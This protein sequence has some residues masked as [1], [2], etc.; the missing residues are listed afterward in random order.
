MKKSQ[1]VWGIRILVAAVF[2]LSA[3]AKLYPTPATGIINFE[4]FYLQEGLG[5]DLSFSKIVSRLLIGLEFTL[6][7]LILLPFYLKKIVIPSIITLLSLFSFHLAIQAIGGDASNCGCFGELIPMTPLEALIKNIL[8]IGLLILPVTIFKDELKEKLNLNPIIIIGLSI[9]LLMFVFVPSISSF[10]EGE[11]IDDSNGVST[12][13]SK[14]FQDVDKGNKLLCFFSPTCEH[15]M[16]TGKEITKLKKKYPGLIP[17]IDHIKI[18]FMD[19]AGNG[20]Q[21]EIESFFDY[22]GANYDYKVLPDDVFVPLF[23]AEK[24]F[25]G[26]LYMYNGIERVFFDGIDENEFD[27]NKL[28]DELKREY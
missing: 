20:S 19:E 2:I 14:Y 17:D 9:S 12:K 6:A 16:E 8:T 21:S 15:C 23:W 5:L 26:V 27:G 11:L 18:F 10:G 7:I 3:V 1:I 4:K 13:Y 24:D 28:I 22:I 25:P